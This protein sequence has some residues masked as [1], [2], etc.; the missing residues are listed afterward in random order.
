MADEA[1]GIDTATD[2]TVAADE[3]IIAKTSVNEVVAKLAF[4]SV[5]QFIAEESVVSLCSNDILDVCQCINRNLLERPVGV[6][7]GQKFAAGPRGPI[8]PKMHLN[9]T[10]K[11]RIEFPGEI[12][13]LVNAA[14]AIDRV[15]AQATKERVVI[16]GTGQDI[17][18]FRTNQI[19]NRN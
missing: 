7:N 19:F 2:T 17:V 5:T 16:G 10:D 9:E 15:V 3:H 8:K 13:H 14:L 1:Y 6:W 12:V 4:E 18:K 11:A